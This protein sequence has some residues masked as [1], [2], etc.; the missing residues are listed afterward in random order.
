MDAL[1]E[2]VRSEPGLGG[3]SY[4]EAIAWIVDDFTFVTDESVPAYGR[5][6]PAL[7]SMIRRAVRAVAGV[8]EDPQPAGDEQ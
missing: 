7:A 5:W 3:M 1:I 4:G 2:E 6:S 8:A